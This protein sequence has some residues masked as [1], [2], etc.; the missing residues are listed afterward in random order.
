MRI[1]FSFLI[2]AIIYLTP[3]ES[4][5]FQWSSIID[6][7]FDFFKGFARKGADNVD[8]VAKTWPQIKQTK[9]GKIIFNDPL[10]KGR[11]GERLTAKRLTGMGYTKLQSKYDEA[12]GIDGVYIKKTNK[13]IEEII[14]T[15]SKVDRSFLNPG[16]P[17]Q[18]SDDW[19]RDRCQKLV[20]SSDR[21]AQETGRMILE[22]M[23]RNPNVIKR[24]LWQHD[25]ESGTTVVKD[26]DLN[27]NVIR[28][29]YRWD[30][31]LIENELKVW[32]EK[33]RLQCIS[34]KP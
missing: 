25:L 5:A 11:L 26:L 33:G 1:V 31:R 24:Q 32:C 7:A 8:E 28:Q 2:I 6:E 13:S 23:D 9:V 21:D 3:L 18:M 4:K 22:A 15:E 34:D 16:P 20:Q 12:H 29:A 14:I 17:K 10:T 19:I 27:A 30:D